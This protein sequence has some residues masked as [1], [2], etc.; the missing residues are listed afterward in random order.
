[1]KKIL[2]LGLALLMVLAMAGAAMAEGKIGVAMPTQSLQRWNQDGANM[3][4]QL[5]AAG[6]EVELTYSDNDVARQVNDIENMLTAGCEVLVIASIDGSSLGTVLETAK[7]MDVPVI[8]YDR[9]ITDTDAVD[10][11]ATFDNYMVGVIQ[12]TYIVDALGLA[13]G[14]GPFNL[15]IV[16]GSPD[17]TNA[18][19]FLAGAMDQLTPYIENGQLV[20][21][22]GQT[23][24]AEVGTMSWKTETAQARFENIITAYYSTGATLD[25]VLCSNDSTAMGVINAL[26]AAGF[27]EFPIITGQD[28]DKPNMQYIVSGIQSMS[29]FKD[30]RTLAEKVVGMVDALMKGAEPEINDTKTYDNGVKV[31]PSY[32]CVPVFANAENYKELLI[33]SGY[34]V[35]V[36]GEFITPDEV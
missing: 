17:D 5:E 24:L 1:M 27:E 13:D 15:E 12:G 23:T 31:V 25:A 22:S 11:Y 4:A 19:Y 6:Y 7:A 28:C 26:T 20:V 14:A 29:V 9:L 10:Y 18:G 34:Y 16:G 35:E 32:L 3:K 30:T 36:N 8:A 33:D 21:P 2:S